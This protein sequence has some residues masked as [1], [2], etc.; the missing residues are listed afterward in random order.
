MLVAVKRPGW[1]CSITRPSPE[2][3]GLT[4]ATSNVGASDGAWASIT[5]AASAPSATAVARKL[6]LVIVA[7]LRRPDHTDYAS[8]GH[9]ETRS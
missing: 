1:F 8:V 3:F 9:R 2:V 6:C 5:G 7:S 4:E